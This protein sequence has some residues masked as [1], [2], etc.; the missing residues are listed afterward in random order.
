MDQRPELHSGF[1]PVALKGPE[2]CESNSL[3][4]S[5]SAGV[6]ERELESLLELRLELVACRFLT[7]AFYSSLAHLASR[8]TQGGQMS[9]TRRFRVPAPFFFSS[10]SATRLASL[11]FFSSD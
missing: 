7:L 3:F 5:S 9:L 2:A 6:L 10:A 8:C 11:T 4:T 1:I